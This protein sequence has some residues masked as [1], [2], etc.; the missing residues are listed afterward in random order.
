MSIERHLFA[1]M[2][3]VKHLPSGVDRE[4]PITL[5]RPAPPFTRETAIRKVAWRTDAWNSR[6][7]ERAALS[8]TLDSEF[9]SGISEIIPSLKRNEGRRGKRRGPCGYC[10]IALNSVLPHIVCVLAC[11][12][13]SSPPV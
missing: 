2:S 13:T 11:A 6:D 1:N 4:T 10:R 9:K 8:Y 12:S 7:A 5:A 3:R